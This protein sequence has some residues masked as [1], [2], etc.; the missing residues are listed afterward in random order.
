MAT[1]LTFV[2]YQTPVPADWLNNVNGFVNYS[3]VVNVTALRA[4]NH[5]IV[6]TVSTAGYYAFN[7]GGGGVYKYDPTDT[8]SSDNGGTVIVANDGARWKL[9]IVNGEVSTAQ[10]GAKF[11]GTTNDTTSIQN[12]LNVLT[13]GYTL[14]IQAGT[15]IVNPLTPP[16]IS[17]AGPGYRVR[18]AGIGV[19][20]LQEAAPGAGVWAGPAGIV[21]ACEFS[22][23]SIKCDPAAPG[24]GIGWLVSGYYNS[25]FKK[26]GYLSNGTGYWGNMFL[27]ESSPNLCYGNVIE[28]IHIFQQV[29]PGIPIA[30]GNNG[31]NNVAFN[32][33]ACRLV[34]GLIGNNTRVGTVIDATRSINTVIDRMWIEANYTTTTL[35]G[36]QADAA[37]G[38]NSGMGT[39]IV[40]TYFEQ[41]NPYVVY[42]ATT[43]GP[44]NYGHVSGNTFSPS[45]QTTTTFFNGAHHNVWVGNNEGGVSVLFSGANGVNWKVGDTLT[46]AAAL[47]SIPVISYFAGTTGS[48]TVASATVL[49]VAVN[50]D[51][52][53]QWHLQWVPFA[54]GPNT[55]SYFAFTSITGYIP[56]TR[57][58]SAMCSAL[59]SIPQATTTDITAN[60]MGVSMVQSDAGN[61]GIDIFVQATYAKVW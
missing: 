1:N 40:D 5:V 11:D 56:V 12:A 14:H 3:N 16:V 58:V 31:T 6:Q 36:H 42:P 38:V 35:T 7:D 28:D 2:D 45:W 50:G 41:H 4:V 39:T 19:T 60:T 23:M 55:A 29:G 51:I 9:Q 10:F 49:R 25:Q 18:G 20:I 33:N 21:F 47:S 59:G 13:S 57:V 26:I 48:L 44:S 24:A 54:S 37:A 22:D 53:Y 15:A 17:G 30:F 61:H 46:P 52:T 8:T 43:D 27:L 34:G 32:A